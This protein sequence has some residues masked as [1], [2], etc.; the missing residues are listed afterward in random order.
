[1]LDLGLYKNWL[2]LAIIGH[3]ILSNRWQGCVRVVLGFAFIVYTRWQGCVRVCCILHV[4]F[5][6]LA[7]N[8]R[9][10]IEILCG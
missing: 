10:A 3:P 8:G 9:S 4:G 7:N 5:I 1:M 6:V 2:A